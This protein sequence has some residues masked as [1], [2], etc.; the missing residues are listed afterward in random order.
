MQVR[1][2]QICL[3]HPNPLLPPKGI[4]LL[5]HGL[6][7]RPAAKRSFQS[8]MYAALYPRPDP[9]ITPSFPYV[10]PQP[11]VGV[12]TVRQGRQV[13]SGL[14]PFGGRLLPGLRSPARNRC[15]V[16]FDGFGYDRRIYQF[17][18]TEVVE[19]IFEGSR[20]AL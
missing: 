10:L 3:S 5:P 7:T 9:V 14:C 13:C 18:Y 19:P 20:R 4:S 16:D 6:A 2:A 15:V 11:Q 17:S 1:Y 8:D 12:Q